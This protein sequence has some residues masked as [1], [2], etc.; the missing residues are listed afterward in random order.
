MALLV[1][2]LGLAVAAFWAYSLICLWS[3]RCWQ[4]T[5]RTAPAVPLP[6]ISVLK[7]LCG[8]DAELPANL[9]SF[10]RQDYRD[11]EVVFGALD[12]DDRGL[13][14]AAALAQ[15]SPSVPVR[16]VAGADEFGLNRKVCTLE[17]LA[18]ESRNPLLVLCDSDMRV[19]PDYL[20]RVAAPFADPEVGLV[21][22]AYCGA[23]VG[24]LAAR[25]EAV[26]IGCDFVPSV[27]LTRRLSGLGFALGATIALRRETLERIGGFRALADELADDYRLGERVRKLRMKVVL[28]DYV[29]DDVMGAE[30]FAR[31]W[32]RRVRWAKTCRAMQPAGWAG[33]VV[34]HG[35]V[36]ALALALAAGLAPWALG[37]LLATVLLRAAVAAAITGCITHDREARRGLWL[38]PVADVLSFAVWLSS[39]LGRTVAWRGRRFRLAPGGKLEPL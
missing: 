18:A 14:D 38:L 3:A 32:S 29:V 36:L 24:S 34:T 30:T 7:P 31:M 21:T 27:M 4:K 22:C 39:F 13:A 33:A 15:G 12:P 23:R 6:A 9:A 37:A 17:R 26:A 11:Y 1:A 16:V 20:A 2:V 5:P 28:S 19:E 8:T 25:L 10:L 35:F